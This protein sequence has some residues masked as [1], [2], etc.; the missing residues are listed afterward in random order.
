[1]PR[2]IRAAAL[3]ITLMVA[4]A[5][6]VSAASPET[7][8]RDIQSNAVANLLVDGLSCPIQ[9]IGG[10]AAATVSV[11][12]IYGHMLQFPIGSGKPGGPWADVS[13]QFNVFCGEESVFSLWA[14]T[15]GV[16]GD[17]DASQLA[18]DPFRSATLK[19]SDLPLHNRDYEP[20]GQ[21]VSFDLVWTAVGHPAPE[22]NREDGYFWQ[23]I[24]APAAVT[25]SV[26][27]TGLDEYD[28]Y[29]LP[30]PLTFSVTDGRDPG[31][32]VGTANE[33]SLP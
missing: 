9:G 23:G 1:M 26:S 13:L 19:I 17:H 21:S 11:G 10:D 20:T 29:G 8:G 14:E 7:G 2:V 4:A 24:A 16:Y 32:R 6:S 33:I 15:Y 31:N 18:I 3:A 5:S 25:G 30:S 27:I 12:F 28:E 22:I